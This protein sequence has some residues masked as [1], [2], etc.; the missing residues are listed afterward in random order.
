MTALIYNGHRLDDILYYGSPEITILA[1]MVNYADNKSR[2]GSVVLGRKWDRSSVSFNVYA[3]GTPLDRRNALSTLGMWLD[4]DEPKPLYLP[5]TPDRYYLAMP[6]GKLELSRCIDGE[7]GKLEFD[8]TDPVAYGEERSITLGRVNGSETTVLVN[9]TY[10][11]RPVIHDPKAVGDTSTQ[12]WGVRLDGSEY[13]HID[14]GYNQHDLV[15]DCSE[16]SVV[17]DTSVKVPTLDSDW[18]ELTP[19]VHTFLRDLGR[20]Y[21]DATITWQERWL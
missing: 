21:A 13:M 20:S 3:V 16:R 5:D 15:V 11:T 1:S 14:V 18:F 9:G 12:I 19:G 8:I 10:P 7:V 4:V 17:S 6:T 2:D